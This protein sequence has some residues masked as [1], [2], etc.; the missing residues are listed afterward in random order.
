[1]K[2]QHFFGAA[3][4]L[5]GMEFNVMVTNPPRLT[6]HQHQMRPHYSEPVLHSP[7]SSS[8]SLSTYRALHFTMSFYIHSFICL[9]SYC[10]LQLQCVNHEISI[11]QHIQ[12]TSDSI[13]N[14]V[15]DFRRISIFCVQVCLKSLPSIP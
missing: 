3:L 5:A 10:W 1:M 7:G 12:I 6:A 2:S 9:S 13:G 15:S 11:S 8:K 14:V 4:T